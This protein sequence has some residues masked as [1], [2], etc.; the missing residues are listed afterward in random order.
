MSSDRPDE[1]PKAK[2]ARKEGEQDLKESFNSSNLSS[3][4]HVDSSSHEKK[5]DQ[6]PVNRQDLGKKSDEIT[7]MI[8]S[9]G[10]EKPQERLSFLIVDSGS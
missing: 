7:E 5:T 3:Y 2:T 9:K 6:G 8:D 4:Q 1:R 10:T